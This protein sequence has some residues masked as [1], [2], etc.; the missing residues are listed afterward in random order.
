MKIE[1][2]NEKYDDYLEPFQPAKRLKISTFKVDDTG[3]RIGETFVKLIINQAIEEKVAEIYVTIFDKH[4]YLIEML[5]DYGFKFKTKKRTYKSD[6]T[7]ELENVLVKDMINKKEFYPF[8]SIKDK[9]VFIIP[10]KEEYHT[11]LFQ[12]YEK[13]VQLSMEDLNGI[14]TAANSLKKAYLCD[15]NTTKI[16]PGSIVLFYSSGIKKAI[17]SLGIVDAVFNKFN[18]FEEMF[19]LVNKRTAYSETELK[20]TFK[21]NKL[22]ILFKIYNYFKK[23]VSYSYLINNKIGRASCRERV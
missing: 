16:E 5:E 1:D 2:E 21:T 17:T 4:K 18:T 11:L 7:V 15:S 9:K 22:V 8:F 10:I 13:Y 3:K 14:N 23:E 12:D 6:G 20:K 19:S